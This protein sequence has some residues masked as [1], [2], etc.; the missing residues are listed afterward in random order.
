MNFLKHRS[1]CM[2]LRVGVVK[3][4]AGI[5]TIG[6][7]FPL[8]SEGPSVQMVALV[9]WSMARALRAPVA[10]RARHRR[11]RRRSGCCG[12]AQRPFRGIRVCHEEL[13]HS[14]RPEFCCY[15]SW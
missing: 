8:G 15:W 14:A 6:S 2:G 13:L 1:V 3:L 7:E 10:F 12:C 9:A 4:V 5:V 11:R